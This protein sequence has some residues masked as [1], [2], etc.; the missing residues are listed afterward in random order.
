MVTKINNQ[1]YEV[2]SNSKTYY[3]NY[4]V[5][6]CTCPVGKHQYAIVNKFNL[7]SEQFFPIHDNLMRKKLYFIAT[8]KNMKHGVMI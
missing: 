8:G 5:G 2:G 6:N 4:T 3:I 7:T 1:E